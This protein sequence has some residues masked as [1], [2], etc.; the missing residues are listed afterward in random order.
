MNRLTVEH[1]V[2]IHDQEL[3]Q[4]NGLSGIKEPGYL[5]FISEKPFGV[6]YG[7]EQ[8]PGLFLKASVLMSSLITSHCFFDANKRTGVLCTYVFLD[9]N[10][11]QL[12]ADWDHLFDV[13]L[14]VANKQMDEQQL[15][16]WLESNSYRT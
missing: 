4:S 8:Y 14:K 1:I 15:A 13:A 12:N 16:C 7:V 6:V 10:G 5:E 9:I 11:Y 2:D 3:Q